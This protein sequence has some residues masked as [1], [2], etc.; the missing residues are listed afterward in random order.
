[1]QRPPALTPGAGGLL[2]A[3]DR[4]GVRLPS[5]YRVGQCESCALTLARG[6][7]AHLTGY[8]GDADACLT[9][10]GV[11]AVPLTDVSLRA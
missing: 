4:R 10:Q 3:A 2:D 7:V 11:Q 8:V 1:M 5:G 9:C 6:S